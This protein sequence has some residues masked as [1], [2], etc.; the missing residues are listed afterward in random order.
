MSYLNLLKYIERLPQTQLHSHISQFLQNATIQYMRQNFRYSIPALRSYS[1][2][3][4]HRQQSLLSQQNLIEERKHPEPN[5]GRDVHPERRRDGAPD[6]LEQRLRRPHGQS[7]RKFVQIAR[8]IPRDDHP[9]QHGEGEDVEEGTE[10]AGQGL[11]PGFGLREQERGRL[12][13]IDAVADG[14]HVGYGKQIHA[15]CASS[16]RSSSR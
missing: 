14:R 15:G 16:G 7:E 13:G 10:D 4:L 6:Q 12:Q 5:D 9:A 1:V 2:L 11:H 8:R 3:D